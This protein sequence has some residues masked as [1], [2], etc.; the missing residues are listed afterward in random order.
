MST[1]IPCDYW[2]GTQTVELGIPWI[3]PESIHYLDNFFL[4]N[5]DV[6]VLEFGAGGSTLYFAKKAKYVLSFETL[7]PWYLKIKEI[8]FTQYPNVD[9]HFVESIDQIVKI[10]GDK[11]FNLSLVDICNISRPDLCKLSLPH[12]Q[13]GSLLVLDNYSADYCDGMDPIFL[14]MQQKPF[15]DAHW[16]G[17]GTK[18]FHV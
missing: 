15:D 16:A 1:L 8:V 7:W 14:N 6:T 18:I 13:P 11:K 3:T 17:S 9:L 12:L 5:K 10:I 2:N 4:A